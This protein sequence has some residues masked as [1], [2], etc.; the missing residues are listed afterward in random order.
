[1]DL[2]R[3]NHHLTFCVGPAQEDYDFHTGLLGLRSIKKT[4]L[5]DGQVPVYHLYY[6]NAH[7]D[8]GTILTSF[9]FRQAGVMGRRGLLEGVADEGQAVLLA[10]LQGSGRD[11]RR[12]VLGA[13]APEAMD[14]GPAVGAVDPAVAHPELEAS[15]LGLGLEHVQR[16]VDLSG[17]DAVAEGGGGG[18]G[19]HGRQLTRPAATLGKRTVGACPAAGAAHYQSATGR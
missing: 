9:P 8:A 3:G 17:V 18:V 1:M 10:D 2:V 4:A 7:G 13:G 14:G 11:G 15:G 12:D 16:A 6:G 5:Y 19:C